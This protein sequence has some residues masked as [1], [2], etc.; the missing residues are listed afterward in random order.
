MMNNKWG[1]V[2]ID[3]VQARFRGEHS[4]TCRG[5]AKRRRMLS[6][7]GYGNDNPGAKSQGMKQ[8]MAGGGVALIGLV[9][10]PLLTGLFG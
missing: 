9:L 6:L 8:L 2:C 5:N 4:E 1:A 7:Q 3:D 10:V